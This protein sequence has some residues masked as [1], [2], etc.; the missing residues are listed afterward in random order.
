MVGPSTSRAGQIMRTMSPSR[1]RASF[2]SDEADSFTERKGSGTSKRSRSRLISLHRKSTIDPHAEDDEEQFKL[3]WKMTYQEENERLTQFRDKLKEEGVLKPTHDIYLLRRFLRARQHDIER[4]SEMFYAHLEWRK[5]NSVDTILSDFVFQERDAFISLYPQG[6]HQTDKQGRPIFIQHLGQIDMVKLN[7]ISNE[8][9][10]IKFHIQEYERCVHYIMPACSKIRGKHID[11]TFA[12]IDV[13][14][15]GLKHFSGDVKK[16]LTRIL[17]IDQNNYPEML[18]HTCIINAP[19]VFKAIWGF[20]RPMLDVRTAGKIEICPTRYLPALL[21]WVDKE[22]LP[23]YLGGTSKAT[24][25]DDVGPWQ[26]P[27]LIAEID[28]EWNLLTGASNIKEEAESEST[29]PSANGAQERAAGESHKEPTPPSPSGTGSAF[30]ATASAHERPLSGE[31]SASVGVPGIP[32][33]KKLKTL[34]SFVGV[35][36]HDAEAVARA[37]SV[38]SLASEDEAYFSPRSVGSGSEAFGDHVDHASEQG[39]PT[40]QAPWGR[41]RL[42]W[43]GFGH[44]SR[45]SQACSRSWGLIHTLGTPHVLAVLPQAEAPLSL[46]GWRPWKTLCECL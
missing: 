40:R 31:S 7:A 28:A 24:L 23:E 5:K 4:A 30:A 3:E 16:M 6:Y 27:R 43:S 21:E 26:D 29:S 25:L 45:N 35:E 42:Y 8:E 41:G 37:G 34:D 19:V 22:N 10:M 15:V 44:W 14:G 12:I 11:Q 9:R 46:L 39:S 36:F 13:K 17:S 2:E 18:G 1:R 33:L 20:I 38:R 32:A